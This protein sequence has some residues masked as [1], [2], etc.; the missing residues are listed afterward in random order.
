M[1]KAAM[2]GQRPP[3]RSLDSG[4][5]GASLFAHEDRFSRSVPFEERKY[6]ILTNRGDEYLRQIETGQWD[7]V[8]LH[9]D[10]TKDRREAQE[11]TGRDIRAM[12]Y[13]VVQ[14]FSAPKLE[15][16]F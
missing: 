4:H 13:K 3:S 16:I 6:L 8:K 1:R 10:W 2:S 14:A 11:F 15:R 12:F 9:F 7:A 5:P